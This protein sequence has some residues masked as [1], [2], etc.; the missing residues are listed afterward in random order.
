MPRFRSLLKVST[1]KAVTVSVDKEFQ[2]T[3]KVWAHLTTICC[4]L[5]VHICTLTTLS[6]FCGHT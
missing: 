5:L 4:T 2:V 3:L 1:Q 6:A